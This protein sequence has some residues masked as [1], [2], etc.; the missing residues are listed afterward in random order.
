MKT[1]KVCNLKKNHFTMALVMFLSISISSFGQVD[2]GAQIASGNAMMMV[3][4]VQKMQETMAKLQDLEP[5]TNDQLKSWFPE[6][7]NGLV[8]QEFEAEEGSMP[9]VASISAA[10]VTP[11][12]PEFLSGPNGEDVLN[13]KR[14][15][16][17]VGVTDGAGPTGSGVIMSMGMM[18]DMNFEMEDDRKQQKVGEVEG[19]KAQQTFHKKTVKT[20]LQFVHGG[21]FG[22][23]I[24]GANMEPQETWGHVKALDL[25]NLPG[26]DN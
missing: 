10:Y 7:I 18:S 26:V 9:N 25:D 24:A 2:D 4:D 12:E 19:I 1:R 21:R 15:T 8:R 3:P 6:S 17:V 22:I 11:D 23:S 5:L 20:E 14:K 16:L 13:P